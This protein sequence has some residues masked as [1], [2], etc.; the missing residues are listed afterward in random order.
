MSDQNDKKLMI[1][2]T[3]NEMQWN[4]IKTTETLLVNDDF[5]FAIP[6]IPPMRKRKEVVSEMY[7]INR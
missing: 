6:A 3:T 5:V 7:I 4:D 1:L 2:E